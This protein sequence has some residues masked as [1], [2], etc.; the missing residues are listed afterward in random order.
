M[1][2][3]HPRLTV[4]IP[5]KPTLS[6]IAARRVI[7]PTERQQMN[8]H[9]ME[10]IPAWAN[11]V[12]EQHSDFESPRNYKITLTGPGPVQNSTIIVGTPR[13]QTEHESTQE[14]LL[15]SI[16]LTIGRKRRHDFG[17]CPSAKR[18]RA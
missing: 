15:D 1:G 17:S 2:S 6:V 11:S 14:N 8:R 18:R 4:K 12:P 7:T 9:R 10:I 5:L 16:S 13:A 3:S